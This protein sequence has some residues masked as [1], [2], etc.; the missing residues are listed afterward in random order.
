[1]L[2]NVGLHLGIDATNIR[3]GGGITHLS[4][5]LQAGDPIAEGVGRVTVLANQTT[6]A[7]LPVRPW[8]F[9]VSSHWMDASLP[10][11]MLGQQFQL[12]RAIKAAGIALKNV[13][14]F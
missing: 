9:K 4:Q 11:R 14:K 13:A 6:A 3:Q 7:A 5:L 12:P 1:M 8:L 10:R 2:E